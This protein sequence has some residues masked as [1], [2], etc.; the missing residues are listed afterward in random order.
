MGDSSK[1]I[2]SYSQISNIASTSIRWLVFSIA[3]CSGVVAICLVTYHFGNLKFAIARREAVKNTC[4]NCPKCLEDPETRSICEALDKGQNEEKLVEYKGLLKDTLTITL[5]LVN[6]KMV[7]TDFV[8]VVLVIGIFFWLWLWHTLKFT[9]GMLCSFY[10]NSRSHFTKSISHTISAYFLLLWSGGARRNFSN[11]PQYIFISFIVVIIIVIFSDYFEYF[12]PYAKSQPLAMYQP[13]WEVFSWFIYGKILI[14]LILFALSTYLFLV[15]QL[16]VK[17]IRNLLLLIEWSQ[18]SLYPM[19]YR[20]FKELGNDLLPGKNEISYDENEKGE[21][22]MRFRLKVKSGTNFKNIIFSSPVNLSKKAQEFS[23]RKHKD[24]KALAWMFPDKTDEENSTF[25]ERRMSRFFYEMLINEKFG[26][27]LARQFYDNVI[28]PLNLREKI[29]FVNTIEQTP[30]ISII[31]KGESITEVVAGYDDE[32]F[33]DEEITMASSGVIRLPE[34]PLTESF[35]E[36]SRP[37]LEGEV[38]IRAIK[39]ERN[40]D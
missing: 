21:F 40:E 4:W 17:D 36:E 3:V 35:W 31:D 15:T 25:E 22:G 16:L 10:N 20:L 27:N 19:L 37:D 30:H 5:P 32:K 13:G 11:L 34:N 1:E 39:D 2:E 9:R 8:V 7:I 12:I 38:V 33:S 29:K 23:K 18:S 28:D 24:R 14:E 26:E 6:L